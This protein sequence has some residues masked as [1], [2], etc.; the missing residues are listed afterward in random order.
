MVVQ[1]VARDSLNDLVDRD[2]LMDRDCFVSQVVVHKG[3]EGDCDGLKDPEGNW[4]GLKDLVVE[5]HKDFDGYEHPVVG[6]EETNTSS[7]LMINHKEVEVVVDV[8]CN[9]ESI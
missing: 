5:D 6:L 2:V 8:L 9:P 1:D 7:V 4:N 3:L